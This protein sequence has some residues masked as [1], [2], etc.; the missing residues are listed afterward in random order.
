MLRRRWSA[1]AASLLVI[2]LFA[3]LKASLPQILRIVAWLLRGREHTERMLAEAGVAE[4][5]SLNP[6]LAAFVDAAAADGRPVYLTARR[7]SPLLEALA[8]RHPGLPGPWSTGAP[9]A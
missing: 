6:R 3:Y 8:A 7:C 9:A 4:A 1:G 2:A 5:L